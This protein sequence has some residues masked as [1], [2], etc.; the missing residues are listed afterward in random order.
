MQLKQLARRPDVSPYILGCG[1]TIVICPR[2]LLSLQLSD[3]KL[4]THGSRILVT[5]D[6]KHRPFAKCGQRLRFD[7]ALRGNS[8]ALLLQLAQTYYPQH[9]EPVCLFC[10]DTRSLRLRVPD[11]PVPLIAILYEARL[12]FREELFLEQE[13]WALALKNLSSI[14]RDPCLPLGY[15]HEALYRLRVKELEAVYGR[16]DFSSSWL[17]D[18]CEF[19]SW[20]PVKQ[21]QFVYGAWGSALPV[22]ALLETICTSTLPEWLYAVLIRT[23]TAEVGFEAVTQPSWLEVPVDPIRHPLP[24]CS[25]LGLLMLS[26][27]G[28][29]GCCNLSCTSRAWRLYFSQGDV[30]RQLFERMFW[31]PSAKES[32]GLLRVAGLRTI[33]W[34]GS[35]LGYAL[36]DC[37]Y[38]CLFLTKLLRMELRDTDSW[39][40]TVT[41]VHYSPGLRRGTLLVLILI[42]GR[43]C[44][45]ECMFDYETTQYCPDLLEGDPARAEAVCQ[46]LEVVL[47]ERTLDEVKVI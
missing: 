20:T 5:A 45:F 36:A 2:R 15:P 8:A 35:C 11:M 26:F 10:D 6:T 30:W 9:N 32:A 16:R 33:D 7:L 28:P 37:P 13:S 19:L 1:T 14:S 42:E 17:V 44:T 12:R 43:E 47:T 29:S 25:D 46:A 34:K 22:E 41:N 38:Q 3:L 31:V 39:S 18:K 40:V 24:W 21:L 4:E 27:V 23:V